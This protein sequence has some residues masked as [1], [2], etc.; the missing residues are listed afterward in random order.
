MINWRQA[1]IIVTN[2]PIS[3]VIYKDI[4]PLT[5]DHYKLIIYNA[6][7]SVAVFNAD[8]R[9]FSNLSTPLILNTYAFGRGV[10]KFNQSKGR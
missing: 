2:L 1:K 9:N 3:Y 5:M 6:R 8:S 4:A 10:I 7:L